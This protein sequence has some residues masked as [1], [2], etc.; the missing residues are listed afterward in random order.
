MKGQD[1]MSF[2]DKIISQRRKY[3]S[4]ASVQGQGSRE[5]QEDAWLMLNAKEAQA[6][7]REPLLALV[8]DGM[9][10]MAAGEEA[11]ALVVSCMAA[12]FR[13]LDTAGD[14]SAQLEDAVQFCN[15]KVYSTFAGDGGSTL[16]A[17]IVY[18]EKL[19][20]TSVGDSGIYLLRAG[21]LSRL[22]RAQNQ[23]EIELLRLVRR[24]SAQ[25][26]TLDIQP[27]HMALSAFVGMPELEDTDHLLYPMQIKAGDSL[28]IC[29]DGV[30]G[31]L[32]E[33]LL[34]QCLS[35]DSPEKACR[36]LEKEIQSLQHPY[37]DNYTAIVLKFGD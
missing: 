36:L 13:A 32:P 31:I 34:Q 7:R 35:A 37:Q 1:K 24:G 28:L 18:D 9:G 30:D 2:F 14:I 8:A 23:L 4:L 20:F 3:C 17:C 29:S 5:N 15:K 27:E 26:D 33:E 22:N 6:G 25:A 12:A 10:G 16:A 19:Y 11:S 21:Q